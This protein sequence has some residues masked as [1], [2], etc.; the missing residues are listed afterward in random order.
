[1]LLLENSV[2]Y[3]TMCKTGK[4]WLRSEWGWW[5]DSLLLSLLFAP[6]GDLGTPREPQGPEDHQAT[7]TQLVCRF[8]SN[9]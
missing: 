2:T 4:K 9:W 7:W 1:M 5:R 8:L 6:C 3:E